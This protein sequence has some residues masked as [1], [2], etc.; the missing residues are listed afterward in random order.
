MLQFSTITIYSVLR[1]FDRV[2]QSVNQFFSHTVLRNAL[3]RLS[4][5]PCLALSRDLYSDFAISVQRPR[6]V[7][8]SITRFSSEGYILVSKSGLHTFVNRYKTKLKFR[9]V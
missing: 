4:K 2:K 5:S 6:I 1:I 9:Y 3:K 8:C 7:Y